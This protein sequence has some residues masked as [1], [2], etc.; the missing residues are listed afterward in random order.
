[1][2]Y[3]LDMHQCIQAQVCYH[4]MCIRSRSNQRHSTVC[5][6]HLVILLSGRMPT[7]Q[8]TVLSQ[9]SHSYCL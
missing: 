6:L 4:I 9:N 3:T 7:L 2:F 1:M 8:Y 5:H